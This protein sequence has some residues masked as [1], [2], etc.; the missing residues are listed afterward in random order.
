MV[1]LIQVPCGA[2]DLEMSI[3]NVVW[4]SEVLSFLVIPCFGKW[5]GVISWLPLKDPIFILNFLSWHE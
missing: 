4:E 1:S 3:F 2:V 5:K